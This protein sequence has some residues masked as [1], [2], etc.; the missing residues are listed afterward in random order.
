MRYRV[1]KITVV[2]LSLLLFSHA[3]VHLHTTRLQAP[4]ESVPLSKKER[5]AFDDTK[6][7]LRLTP[8]Y[9]FSPL[10]HLANI[11]WGLWGAALVLFTALCGRGQLDRDRLGQAGSSKQDIPKELL[12]NPLITHRRPPP[13]QL[14][15]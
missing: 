1:A 14:L 15:A 6:Q 4:S 2:T 9:V 13:Y 8:L 12:N 11:V 5:L 7:K 10:L 3:L